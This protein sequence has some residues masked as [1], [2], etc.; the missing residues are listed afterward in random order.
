MEKFTFLLVSWCL[1]AITSKGQQP[2]RIK[3]YNKILKSYLFSDPNPIPSYTNIYPYFRFDGFTDKAVEKAWK[4]VDLEN[5]YIKLTILPEIG[6]RIWSAVEKKTGKAF[7]YENHVVKF[8]DIALRG[9]WLSGGLE[10]NYGIFGHTPGT[11]TPVDYLTRTNTDGSVSCFISLLDLLTR[12]TWVMEINLPSDKAYFSTRSF[13]HN[14]N[15]L[16]V[17]YYHWMNA[18]VKTEGDLEFIFPGTGYIGHSGEYSNWPLKARKNLARYDQNAFGGYKSYHVLGTRTDFFAAYLHRDRYGVVRY[19][20]RDEKA[21][22]KIWI[23]GQSRQGMIWEKLL[24]DRDGPYAEI[25][26]GRLFNQT[27]VTSSYT[28]FKHLSFAPAATDT[29]TEYWYPVLETGGVV[30]A[31]AYG[32]LNVRMEKQRLNIYFCPVQRID[33]LLQVWQK[34][35]LAYEKKLKLEPLQRFVVSLPLRDTTGIRI[36]MGEN[37]LVYQA[38]TASNTL[39]RPVQS[40]SGINWNT[41]YGLYVQGKELMDHKLYDLAESKLRASLTKE[42]YF[43]PSLVQLAALLYHKMEYEDALQVLRTA[44]SLNTYDGPANYYYGLV[45]MEL[46]R[47]AD[48]KDGLEIACLTPSFRPAAYNGLA[49]ICLRENSVTQA[50]HY[51]AKAM[52][53]NPGNIT[54]LEIMTVCYRKMKNKQASAQAF[55][56]ILA[57]NPLSHFARFEQFLWKPDQT[58]KLEF[59][60]QIRNELPVET[61]LELASTYERMGRL[62]ES[63]QVLEL[64]PPQALVFFKRAYLKHRMG[65]DYKPDLLLAIQASPAF[66]FPFRNSDEP[67]LRWAVE[68]CADWKPRYFLAL[69]YKDRNRVA[70]YQKAFQSC[71]EQ[72]DYA[73]FYAARAQVQLE[74]TELSDLRKAVRLDPDSWRYQKLLTEYFS[75]RGA[76]KQALEVISA[77]QG[78]HPENYLTGLVYANTLL[79]DKQYSKCLEVLMEQHILPF[80]G[81]TTSRR[82]YRQALLHLALEAIEK[83]QPKTAISFIER[84][85]LWPEQLGV[86]KPYDASLDQRM[87][88]WLSFRVCQI[89]GNPKQAIRYL[90][91]IVAFEPDIENGVRNFLQ[92]NNLLSAWALMRIKGRVHALRWLQTQLKLHPHDDIL[93]WSKEN[94]DQHQLSANHITASEQKILAQ[95]LGFE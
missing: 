18:A 53:G 75:N 81:A 67:M 73:P 51:A 21:G 58:H 86:G 80:E 65:G 35:H 61:Y 59:Q 93:R 34:D 13:W 5:D 49:W 40:P 29:W 3:T 42:A 37:K 12:T 7:L 32:A 45:N 4:A 8:R 17:P 16:E 48:A 77:F 26:S 15:P 91:R 41:A 36:K 72:P 6:G 68:A 78:K 25:Q 87:E 27:E 64:A 2:A 92:G 70:D 23:W 9:P 95:L 43:L 28:P 50:L 88:D 83:Q 89:S 82:I 1:L 85:R 31:N 74:R 76:Y 39:S 30:E 24:T 11:A 63:I 55:S 71:G 52:E 84:C 90:E 20:P 60:S 69:L 14:A 46:N 79:L 19:A 94:F 10:A 66:V 54:A 56:T 38:D 57:L 44:L 62:S 22:K 47:V 33:D